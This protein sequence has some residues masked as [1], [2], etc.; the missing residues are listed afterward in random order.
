MLAIKTREFSIGKLMV[1]NYMDAIFNQPP[2]QCLPCFYLLLLFCL[3][4]KLCLN[5]GLE[6]AKGILFGLFS[7][8]IVIDSFVPKF[9]YGL[10]CALG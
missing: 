10:V 1:K 9:F 2:L 8:N 7:H 4:S 3:E 6:L 5:F